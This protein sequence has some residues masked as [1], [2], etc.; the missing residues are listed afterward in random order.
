MLRKLQYTFLCREQD[1]TK[2][3]KISTEN[4]PNESVAKLKYFRTI[5]DGFV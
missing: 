2:Y 3:D 5:H 4:I 1:V